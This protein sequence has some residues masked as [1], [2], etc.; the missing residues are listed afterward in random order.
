VVQGLIKW[1]LAP[2]YLATWEDLEVL[3]HHFPAVSTWGQAA[4]QGGGGVLQLMTHWREAT[5]RR[6]KSLSWWAVEL[7]S[8]PVSQ[9]LAYVAQSGVSSVVKGMTSI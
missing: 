5:K 3:R 4:A 8:G 1:L 9:I 2:E 7:A 6:L